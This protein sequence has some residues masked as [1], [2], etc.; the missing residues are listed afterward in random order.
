MSERIRNL[1]VYI[2]KCIIGTLTVFIIA[3]FLN[4]KDFGWSLI[5]VI[6]VLSPER[7]DSVEVALIRIIANIIGAF[8]GLVCLLFSATNMWILSIGLAAT[9]S[10]CYLFKLDGSA[11]SALA[12]TIIIMLHQEGKHIWDNALQRVVAVLM[13]CFLGLIIT[14]LF[15]FKQKKL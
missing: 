7:K 10:V 13:G 2:A 12:A 5:S 11:R 1:L 6:L 14:F 4:F 9:L 3:S 8:I 15:H